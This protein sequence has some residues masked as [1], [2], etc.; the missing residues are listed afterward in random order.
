MK[1]RVYVETS[2]ISY[3]TARPHHDVIV[4][5]HQKATHD[6]WKTASETFSLV[7]SELVVQEA[8]AGDALAARKRLEALQ[9]LQ[10]LEVAE[11][12]V[13]LADLLVRFQA[14]PAKAGEDALH[15]A[16]CATNG[17]EYLVTWNCRHIA[18]AAI[19]GQIESVCRD[20]GFEPPVICTPDEIAGS[21]G[22]VMD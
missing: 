14:V 10:L 18:N 12:A 17:V 8:S 11:I 7:A 16:I 20:A 9:P 13:D 3:L 4:A 19:R 2:V 5:G 1:P 15:I 21:Y 22:G 6:W